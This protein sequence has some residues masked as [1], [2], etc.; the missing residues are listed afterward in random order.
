MKN[1]YKQGL[2]AFLLVFSMVFSPLLTIA[3]VVEE[4]TP[5]EVVEETIE[6][7]V[8]EEVLDTTDVVEET[9]PK[10]V[11]EETIEK[12][13]I[14]KVLD[15]TDAVEVI[16][17]PTVVT[18][19]P[20]EENLI[21]E[22]VNQV[23]D[24]LVA[25]L[26][27][28]Q[29][30]PE[31]LVVESNTKTFVEKIELGIVYK[32]KNNNQVQVTF[33]KLPENAGS[34]TIEEITLTDAQVKEFG[35]VS[36]IAYDITSSMEN[37]SFEYDLKLPIPSG[38][39]A[40]SK[41]IYAETV[42]DLSNGN[43]SVVDEEKVSIDASNDTVSVS[44]LDHFTIFVVTRTS[45]NFS[46]LVWTADRA[47]PTGGWIETTNT[48][49]MNIDAS[50]Q[51]PGTHERTEG[52]QAD[53]PAGNNSVKA[54]LHIDNAWNGVNYVRAGLWGKVGKVI[55]P[56]NGDTAWPIMEFTNEGSNPR[57][58]V[59]DTISGGWTNVDQVVSYGDIVD[60]EVVQNPHTDEF[61]FYLN[62]ILVDSYSSIG[63]VDNYEFYDGLILNAYNNGGSDYGV[64][65][66]DLEIGVIEIH[67]EANDSSFLS[68]EKFVK[69]NNASDLA[70]QIRVPED[71]ESI[72]FN[73]DG[74]STPSV[75]NVSG[76]EHIQS[77][78][79]PK[80]NGDRQFR[81]KTALP[82][83]E[84]DVTAEFLLDGNW[85]PV[86]GTAKVYS[87]ENPVTSI[88]YPND[89]RYIF[90]PSDAN[91]VRL[92][93]DDTFSSF[94][95]AE[96]KI[97]ATTYEV[98]RNTPGVDLR[99]AGKYVL[100]DITKAPNWTPLSEGIYV[101]TINAWN[102]ANGRASTLHIPTREFIIDSTKPVVSNFI[103]PNLVSGLNID[104]ATFSV[105]AKAIDANGID[106]VRFYLAELPE[107]GIPKNN[108]PAIRDA[109][110]VLGAD[111][112][113][114]AQLDASGLDGTY[115]VLVSAKDIA[116][117]NSIP[118]FTTVVIDN[119]APSTPVHVSPANNSERKTVDQVKIDWTDSTDA[120]SPVTYIYQSSN[121]S[122]TNPDGSFTSPVFTSSPLAVS[123]IPTTGTPEGV[124]YWHVKAIDSV[125]NASPWSVAWKITVDNTAPAVPTG[126]SWTDS[127]SNPVSDE[128][129]TELEMG[130][131][132]WSANNE[133]DFSHYTYKYWNDI[134]TSTYNGESNAYVNSNLTS[135]SLA[136]AFN[137]GYGVHHFCIIAVD[138]AG[139]QSA[140]SA[141][142]T[143]TYT[144]PVVIVTP[145]TQTIEEVVVTEDDLEGWVEVNTV[146]G[147]VSFV[148]D[149]DAPLGVGALRLTTQ[150][151]VQDRA[152]LV[153]SQNTLLSDVTELEYSTKRGFGF[154]DEGNAAYRLKIDADGDLGTVN[155]Q[156][157]LVFEPYWQNGGSPDSA[158]NAQDVWQTWDVDS[159]LFWASIPGG[160]AITGMTNGAGG[161]PFYTIAEVLGL[162]P[163]TKVINHSVGIGS[164]N[165]NY[166]VLIDKVVF[167]TSL[168]K[169]TYDME[170]TLIFIA[171]AIAA[172][173]EVSSSRR[174][175]SGSRISPPAGL[176][177]SA[178][179][180]LGAS[181][182][183][184]ESCEMY[185]KT[186][187]NEGGVN[188]S[189]E[190]SLLQTFLVTNG[191]LTMPVGVAKGFF[192][193]LTKSAVVGL[194]NKYSD[195]LLKPWGLAE[196]TGNVFKTTRWKIN[197]L[198]CDGSEDFPIIP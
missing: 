68:Q 111:D 178:G 196:G 54:T 14:E 180:V 62:G 130:T 157:T 88:V 170:P 120:S 28:E 52:V 36:N 127:E 126:L 78:Q 165:L 49:V 51:A 128:G 116:A 12:V 181:T 183:L 163:N 10:E 124:Y 103:V 35:A 115:V 84:Y 194:Q 110:G 19:N 26:L 145:P 140:C 96:F 45:Q 147:E 148:E 193:S 3:Q 158:P 94:K 149:F 6:K 72:L 77:G 125:G 195:E 53:I 31:T 104:T 16:E 44:D 112:T 82:A 71:A 70:A 166:D 131:A 159:G 105:S 139:N 109:F 161:P 186:Y 154:A 32:H 65:W 137:Q 13:V 192:G 40:I 189:T 188:D 155:D 50:N 93:I 55:N 43:T 61:E 174:G 30:V 63:G 164:Y 113:Y 132:V 60:F 122:N 197:N 86:T 34:L 47:A 27:V 182:G 108:L 102:Q 64:T 97:N 142:F 18:E 106:S 38:T 171:P 101:A 167:A 151:D 74:V 87:I 133:S 41:V 150:S 146:S 141:P 162:H 1:F 179:S 184:G 85:F 58:R 37:G 99:Q 187:M 20:K 156:A 7:V 42:E 160:N 169:V 190:V 100:V 23:V 69:A 2:L 95:R 17:T 98:N 73:F 5:K 8:A 123:E 89:T 152:S 11:V 67:A 9:T 153:K 59:W 175:R 76:I 176:S 22:L 136:G 90:R 15:T 21:T 29:E 185:I 80:T 138:N 75:E 173:E 81:I 177:G 143:I 33:T 46:G 91:I 134:A 83:G 135:T 191:F 168:E 119:T 118:L 48:L 66:S 144:E 117:S 24:E 121:S 25:P 56:A 39:E 92:R 107:N 79:W 4:T 172:I 198:N 57:V 114:T 129:S